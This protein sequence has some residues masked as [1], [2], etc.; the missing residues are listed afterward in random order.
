MSFEIKMSFL[1]EL[2]A[3]LSDK[4]TVNSMSTVMS[5][6]AD[7]LE[8]YEF[9]RMLRI[10]E[11]YS[12]DL[13]DTWIS[14]LKV[15]GRSPK[16]IEAYTYLVNRLLKDLQVPIRSIT[17]YHLRNW[18]TKEKE[19]G[20][21]DNTLKGNREVFSSMFGWLWREGLID[22]NPVTN[23]GAIKVQK[24]VR[25]PYTDIELDQLKFACM[26]QRDL[27]IVTFLLAT[28]CRVGEV[29]NIDKKDI[30]FHINEVTVLGKGNKERV[31][32]FDDVTAMHLKRYIRS[33]K[34]DNPCLFCSI[35]GTRLTDNG[36]RAMLKVL[37]EKA[38]VK[39]VH[40]H[41]FRRTLAT[42][43]IKH[44]MPI[45]EVAAILGHEKLDTTMKY[46]CLDKTS[47]KNSYHK[48][49]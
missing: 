12:L 7:I 33:R 11:S 14:A 16:T 10:E 38:G 6:V 5:S 41:K 43:L 2:E 26:S 32:F 39:N 19:R 17:V 15:E 18:L 46:V 8:H 29:V 37:A 22:K 45:Q 3:D 28:G 27:A 44:G 23:I 42:M 24:K 35:R 48:Y 47:V 1:K 13:L 34:D 31:V 30:N 49:A 36:I 4:I 40:P 9:S 20:I 25:E 21:S